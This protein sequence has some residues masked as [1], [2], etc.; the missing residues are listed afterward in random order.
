L[1]PE[2]PAHLAARFEAFADHYRQRYQPRLMAA[3]QVRGIEVMD[4]AL[5]DRRPAVIR[6][7]EARA[8]AALLWRSRLRSLARL[9]REPFLY[10][11]WFPYLVGKLRRA[12]A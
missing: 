12:W 1:R 9:G 5:V 11:G 3:A 6:R 4:G 10:R 7:R 2:R 8:L